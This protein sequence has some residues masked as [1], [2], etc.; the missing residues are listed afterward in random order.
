MALLEVGLEQEGDV[1]RGRAALGHLDLEHGQVLGAEPFPPRGTRLLQE[2]FGHLGLAPD[3]APVEETERDP[4]VLGRRAE[5]LG[6]PAHRVVEVHALVPHRVP[7]PVGHGPDVPA[8]IV[9]EHHIEVAEG[10]Q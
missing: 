4:G 2:G 5:H 8:P 9:D 3:E 10:T 6:G 7:D 1:A